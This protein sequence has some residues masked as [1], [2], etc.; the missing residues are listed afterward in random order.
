MS[1][2]LEAEM[3]TVVG[4]LWTYLLPERSARGHGMWGWAGGQEEEREEEG[5]I[6]LQLPLEKSRESDKAGDMGKVE[7]G[8]AVTG[9]G[10]VE[11]EAEKLG[12]LTGRGQ[13]S[14]RKRREQGSKAKRS[15]CHTNPNRSS[16][17]WCSL[18]SLGQP[19]GNPWELSQ[20]F[21]PLM[22]LGANALL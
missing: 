8:E 5:E 1:P 10:V 21:C 20:S 11:M 16:S 19:P 22:S 14:N 13:H 9:P 18:S 2:G 7:R 17:E 3:G 12:R 15:Q 4:D 6:G